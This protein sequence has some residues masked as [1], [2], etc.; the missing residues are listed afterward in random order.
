MRMRRSF[1]FSPFSHLSSCKIAINLEPQVERDFL[2]AAEWASDH[3]L[4]WMDRQTICLRVARWRY[5]EAHFF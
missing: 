4:I 2:C 3:F 5:D 1:A